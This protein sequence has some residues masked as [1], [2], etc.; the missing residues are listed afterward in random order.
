[1]L[2]EVGDGGD[3]RVGLQR[4][5]AERA[6]DNLGDG[7]IVFFASLAI[8]S[9]FAGGVDDHQRDRSSA[10]NIVAT[11]TSVSSHNCCTSRRSLVAAVSTMPWA[12]T[13]SSTDEARRKSG[14]NSISET[15]PA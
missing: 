4:D 14:S 12:L 9:S 2:A 7:G 5:G 15:T 8:A 6:H 10:L 3:E 11:E 1:M 13:I